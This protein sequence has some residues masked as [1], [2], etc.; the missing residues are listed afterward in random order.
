MNSLNIISARVSPPQTPNPSRSNSFGNLLSSVNESRRNSRGTLLNEKSEGE[1]EDTQ[2]AQKDG[3]GTYEEA[4]HEETPLIEKPESQYVS[5][6]PSGWNIIPRLSRTLVD[7]IR[8]VLSTLAAPGVYLI[9]FLY[10]ERG[11][12]A[13]FSQI[14]KFGSPRSTPVREAL[15]ASTDDD[16]VLTHRGNGKG[17]TGRRQSVKLPQPGASAASSSAILS[18][19]ES[20]PDG[21]VDEAESTPGG[22]NRQTRSKSQQSSDDNTPTR[23][24]IR[25]KLNND[26]S[27][28]ERK[29]R[30]SQPPI[31]Q[32]NGAGAILATEI[33]PA[34]LKSPTSPAASSLSLTK[35]PRAPAPPR[36]LI[37]RRQPSYAL[38]DA[39]NGRITQKTL[40]LDLD[41][42]L[43]HSMA[44]GGRMSTGH[45]VEVKLNTLVAA[46]GN[47]SLG[48]Q[49]PILYYVHKRP[50]CDDFLRRV[51]FLPAPG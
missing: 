30:K 27:L 46:G 13:P 34:A 5:L 2:E 40:I 39:P 43:I 41:E 50:H 35:Y 9:A 17:A 12:F 45:M 21:T 31:T 25:I 37:P 36:P 44:K 38:P 11:N 26:D 6:E 3:D 51:S 20:E 19:S 22:S 23:R 14:R 28:R 8:W 33:S 16:N 49:H 15:E 1:T 29:R 48:P 42:T 4:A 47:T 32:S 7:S 10:D 24:S 18:E